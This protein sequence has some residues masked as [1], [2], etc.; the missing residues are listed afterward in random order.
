MIEGGNP[1]LVVGSPLYCSS[2]PL[3]RVRECFAIYRRR[4]EEGRY[5]LHVQPDCY[6]AVWT[7]TVAQ[8]VLKQGGVYL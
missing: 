7:S 8:G 1:D 5:F 4:M 2:N 6:D 3:H